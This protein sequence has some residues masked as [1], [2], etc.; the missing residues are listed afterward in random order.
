MF[1]KNKWSGLEN[2]T[3]LQL[4]ER[5]RE[6]GDAGTAISA[7]SS[8]QNTSEKGLVRRARSC[9]PAFVTRRSSETCFR[10]TKL[11]LT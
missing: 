10:P 1:P 9:A 7:K 11:A 8:L 3:Q 5:R 6:G 4:R 2:L